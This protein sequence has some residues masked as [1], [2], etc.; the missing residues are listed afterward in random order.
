MGDIKMNKLLVCVLLGV[1]LASV[2]ADKHHGKRPKFCGKNMCPKF[3]TVAKRRGYEVRCYA[4]T[5]W[6]QTMASQVNQKQFKKEFWRLF[7]YISGNNAE[8]KKYKMTVPVLTWNNYNMSTHA[9]KSGLGFWIP[10]RCNSTAP[11]PKDSAVTIHSYGKFCAY[12]RSYGGYSIGLTKWDYKNLYYLSK[13]IKAS[14][15]SYYPGVSSMA[16]YNSPKQKFFRHNEVWR[17]PS[18]KDQ[19]EYLKMVKDPKINGK[20]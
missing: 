1:V 18:K 10:T 4:P 17:M 13:A 8:G 11:A 9:T 5:T 15:K 19:E 20:C 16:G 2:A 3:W 7:K 12:V 6:A 14:G